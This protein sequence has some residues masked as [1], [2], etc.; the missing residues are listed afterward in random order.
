MAKTVREQQE[1]RRQEKLKLVQQQ[2]DD[3][4]LVI[5]KMTPAER[6]AN[7]PRPAAEKPTGRKR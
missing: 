1:K 4:S 2:V 3:G 7:P 6:K 5:R